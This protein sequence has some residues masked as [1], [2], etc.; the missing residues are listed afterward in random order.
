MG[1]ITLL[2]GAHGVGKTTLALYWALAAAEPEHRTVF[3][4]FGE[5]EAELSEKARTFGLDLGPALASGAL[6]FI[7]LSPSEIEPD[8][9]AAHLLAALTPTTARLVID[10]SAALV[11]ALGARAQDYL[12][13][14]ATHLSSAGVTSLFV[15]GIDLFAGHGFYVTPTPLTLVAQNVVVMHHVAIDGVLHRLL[16][17]LKMR[18]SAHA[19]TLHEVV[20]AEG[21]VRVLGRTEMT[22][23]VRQATTAISGGSSTP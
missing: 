16:G 18:L 10:D 13:A 12:G 9:V 17:V 15:V 23:S 4:T 21:S 8:M 7:H 3:F 6:A 5:Y 20:L 19:Q 22:P 11:Q 14:L 1:T 2:A